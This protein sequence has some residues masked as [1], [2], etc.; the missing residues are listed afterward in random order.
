MKTCIY[1]KNDGCLLLKVCNISCNTSGRWCY[2]RCWPNNQAAQLKMLKR[3]YIE[4]PPLPDGVDLLEWA[5]TCEANGT[6]KY[7]R[8]GLKEAK[9]A[10]K[11]QLKERKEKLEAIAKDLKLP[12]PIQMARNLGKHLHA[13]KAHKDKTGRVYRTP[14]AAEV[15]RA[16]CRNCPSNKAKID[17]DGILRC[18]DKRCGCYID[19]P[20]EPTPLRK[21][22]GKLAGKAIGE[23][24]L[25]SKPD[26]E[27]LYCEDGHW[28]IRSSNPNSSSRSQSGAIAGLTDT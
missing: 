22:A 18:T 19:M 27:A 14:E 23:D 2:A 20:I 28:G 13:I 3:L 9:E 24:T 25:L 8:P 6:V 5:K 21:L 16:I 12:N 7:T 4:L 15:C 17:D 1:T 11:K 10:Q 26:Y